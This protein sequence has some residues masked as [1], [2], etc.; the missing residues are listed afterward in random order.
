MLTEMVEYGLKI[1]E[2]V[3]AMW[4]E[5]KEN[6]QG[7]NSEEKETGAQINGLEQKEEINFQPEQNEETRILKNEE[8][9]RNLWHNCKHP[10]SES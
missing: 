7:N 9:L 1:E 5:I 10:T 6:V 8:R 2:E 3:K 4:S